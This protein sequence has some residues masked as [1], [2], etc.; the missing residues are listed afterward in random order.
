MI[1]IYNLKTLDLLQ[2]HVDSIVALIETSPHASVFKDL[3]ASALNL[4]LSK[5]IENNGLVLKV[6]DGQSAI[7][8]LVAQVQKGHE[9]SVLELWVDPDAEERV[10]DLLFEQ[11][12]RELKRRE[13]DA[14]YCNHD[15]FLSV[16][17]KMIRDKFVQTR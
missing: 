13:F 14:I 15:W 16:D 9:F 7:G 1:T 4:E 11:C 2:N 6:N 17:N 10:V 3:D 12:Q 8:I 5:I